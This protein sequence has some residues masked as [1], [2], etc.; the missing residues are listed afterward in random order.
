MSYM[1]LMGVGVVSTW[2]RRENKNHEIFPLYGRS[3]TL[4]GLKEIRAA[5]KQ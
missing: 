4:S 5:L 3:C 1:E 2:R